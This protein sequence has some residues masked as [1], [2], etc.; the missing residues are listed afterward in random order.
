MERKYQ[1]D[2]LLMPAVVK[3]LKTALFAAR[4]A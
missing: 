2:F 3:L 4:Y 1:P